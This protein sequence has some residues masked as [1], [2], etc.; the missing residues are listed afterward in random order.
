[1]GQYQNIIIPVINS[2]TILLLHKYE[3]PNIIKYCE[4]RKYTV[5]LS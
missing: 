3:I 1:M 5:T 2:N 4:Y